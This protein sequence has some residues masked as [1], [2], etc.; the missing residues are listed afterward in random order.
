[1]T[2][3]ERVWR[4]LDKLAII[5]ILVVSATLMWRI[6]L[7]HDS[8]NR[9]PIGIE[10][11]DLGFSEFSGTLGGAIVN[12]SLA[13][14]ANDARVAIVE[15]SDYECPFC[16]SFANQSYPAIKREFVDTGLV[17]YVLRDEPSTRTVTPRG[18]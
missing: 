11:S 1:M 6:M 2:R 7:P 14:G 17:K 16:A 15:F 4:A 18:S 8:S 12:G 5:A 13:D 3:L 9:E 10:T